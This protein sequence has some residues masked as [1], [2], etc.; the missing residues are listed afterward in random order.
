MLD[1]TKVSAEFAACALEAASAPIVTKASRHT[2]D[3]KLAADFAE[4]G[5]TIAL[6]SSSYLESTDSEI[7]GVA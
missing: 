5:K 7:H 3:L 6:I 4:C 2:T 1:W